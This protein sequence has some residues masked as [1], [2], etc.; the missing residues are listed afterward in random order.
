MIA[1]GP[2]A[3]LK[4][5]LKDTVAQHTD[6]KYLNDICTRLRLILIWFNFRCGKTKEHC[7][8]SCQSNCSA[9]NIDSS[10]GLVNNG[11]V[12]LGRLIDS[13]VVPGT[14]AI[15]FDDGPVSITKDLL[16][17]LAE[18]EVK[19]TFFVIGEQIADNAETLKSAFDAGHHIASHTWNHPD[20]KTLS[21]E[22]VALQMKNTSD[23]IFNVLGKR[24]Q[25]MRP[26]YGSVSDQTL[27]VLGSLGYKVIYWNLDTLD[28]ETKDGEKTLEAY[29]QYLSTASV[30]SSSIL[31][32]Q[33][34]IQDSTIGVAGNIID[35]VKEAGYKIVT[36]P[37]CLGDTG[38]YY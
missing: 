9:E 20:L 13:C 2:V 15:T 6:G 8:D 37:E 25:Y 23:A 34:D 30:E 1:S 14:A 29:Q 35:L 16:A 31:S 17:T 24:P 21:D 32:L 36:V 10:V 38:L 33:H 28:W 11:T 26:P 22:D 7:V 12:P 19:V 27:Q 3:P 4:H 18:K 5:V